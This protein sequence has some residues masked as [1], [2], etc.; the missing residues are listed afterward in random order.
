MTYNARHSIVAPR[1]NSI[2]LQT[3]IARALCSLVASR[4]RCDKCHIQ[5]APTAAT[6]AAAAPKH[7]VAYCKRLPVNGSSGTPTGRT[8]D[9]P[10]APLSTEQQTQCAI[11]TRPTPYSVCVSVQFCGRTYNCAYARDQ[12]TLYDGVYT[13][14]IPNA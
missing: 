7:P 8:C 11:R 13:S 2:E 9:I 4:R 12:A 5:S 1:S 14:L 3:L 10:K 6:A